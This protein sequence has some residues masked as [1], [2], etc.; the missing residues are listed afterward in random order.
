MTERIDAASAGSSKVAIETADQT[1]TTA[2]ATGTR[3][4]TLSKSTSSIGQSI[5]LR[6]AP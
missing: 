5:A 3:T 6:P 1:L 4:A 2:G